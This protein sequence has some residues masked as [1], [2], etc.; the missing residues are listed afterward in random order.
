MIKPLSLIAFSAALAI[1]SLSAQ[2]SPKIITGGDNPVY[3]ETR[4]G[5]IYSNSEFVWPHSK[6]RGGDAYNGPAHTTATKTFYVH[7]PKK[8]G[9]NKNQ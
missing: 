8:G 1:G 5:S 3:F 9:D 7:G 2:A 6:T 4:T